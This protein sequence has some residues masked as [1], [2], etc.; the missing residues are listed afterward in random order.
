MNTQLKLSERTINALGKIVTG[1]GKLSSYRG[2][3]SLVA[4]FNEFGRNDVYGQGFPSRW[5][6]AEDSIR[7]LNE[8]PG[9]FLLIEKIFDPREFLDTEF[10][11]EKAIEFFNQYFSYEKHQIVLVGGYAKVRDLNG[12]SVDFEHP[13]K[14]SKEDVH[15]FI[16]EQARKCDEKI[17]SGDYYGA[18]TNARSLVE[19]VLTEIEKDLDSNAPEYDGDLIKLYRRVAKLINLGPERKDISDTLKQVL[20]GLNSIIAG[21]AGLRNKMSDAHVASYKP[22]KHHAK[23]AVNSAKTICD[24]LFESKQYQQRCKNG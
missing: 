16:D 10:N 12:V 23:L 9:I 5:K 3:P 14:A 18:I 7:Q 24:F 17:S 21:L 11:L 8:T 15:I 2:G 1:D 6:Y 13:F 22:S 4:L 19:A 20:A